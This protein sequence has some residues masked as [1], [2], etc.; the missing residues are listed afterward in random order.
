M[1]LVEITEVA[2]GLVLVFM[3]MSLAVMY[4]QE[5]ITGALNKRSENLEEILRSMLAESLTGKKI[6]LAGVWDRLLTWLKIKPPTE[7]S[8][9]NASGVFE[10]LY[11]HPLI[12]TLA[13]GDGKPSY[14]PADKFVLALFDTVMT[15][16]TDASTIQKALQSLKDY[17]DHLPAEMQ[18]ILDKQVDALMTQAGTVGDDFL[19]LGALRK[20]VEAFT[21]QFSLI[22][23]RV[24]E[25]VAA[26]K[27]SN[28]NA[29]SILKTLEDLKGYLQG[30]PD[31]LK[32][33]L[34]AQLEPLIAR[35]Q[36]AGEDL[37]ALAAL[38]SDVDAFT[39][40]FAGVDL[41]SVFDAVL[42]A[43][44]PT[45]EASVLAA[46]R[47]G[48]SLLTVEN[49]QLK[50]TLD[51]IVQQAEIFTKEGEAKIGAA[52][53]AAEKWFNDVMD[54]AGGWYKR[55]AQR[56]GLLIGFLLA[57][58]FNV[59][60]L[61]IANQLWVQPA[62]REGVV[63]AAESYQYPTDISDEK[64][65]E[66]AKTAIANLNKSL[67]SLGLPLGW[68]IT[69]AAYDPAAGCPVWDETITTPYRGL[70]LRTTC[71]TLL[72]AP[73]GLAGWLL[74]LLGI[75]ITGAATMQGAPFWFDMLKKII[76]VRSTGAKPEEKEQGKK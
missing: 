19:Q 1:Y 36:A 45:D 34:L 24:S 71:Y 16:G 42:H 15:T 59:D 49:P 43:K 7:L 70:R 38:R 3:V 56:V 66:E 27:K 2:I 73:T 46:L 41:A 8:A 62:L 22:Q 35:A 11:Q 69:A 63:K 65:I 32:Q 58:A 13:K 64:S 48:S 61:A 75:F 9:Q 25:V 31:E 57:F 12:R 68:K 76:N 51:D 67:T 40:K 53:Q 47:R 28:L 72:E 18:S 26:L 50:A 33:P 44:I 37:A 39:K 5:S 6:G 60:S 17:K 21:S 29:A 55:E 23:Q 4:I 74:K 30:L 20:A 52:R 14:I 54:R 10:K